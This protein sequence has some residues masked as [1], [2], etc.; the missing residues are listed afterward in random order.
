MIRDNEYWKPFD[1][2]RDF[3]S[4][5]SVDGRIIYVNHNNEVILLHHGGERKVLNRKKGKKTY[6]YEEAVKVMENYI[7]K[8]IENR[9]QEQIIHEAEIESRH[10][11][12]GDRD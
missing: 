2:K 7:N 12:W 1:T 5:Q 8:D 10:G 3:I 4:Y 6:V 11:D 9:K